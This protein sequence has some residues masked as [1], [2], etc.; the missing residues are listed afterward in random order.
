MAQAQRRHLA[1]AGKQARVAENGDRAHAAEERARANGDRFC[2]AANTHVADLIAPV[3]PRDEVVDPIV[4]QS[5]GQLDAGFDELRVNSI[6]NVH[7]EIAH[8]LNR[9]WPA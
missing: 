9:I 2:F 6:V 3:D 4:G 1:R 8:F 7:R 5:R